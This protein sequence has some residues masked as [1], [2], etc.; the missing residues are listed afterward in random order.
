MFIAGLHKLTLIDYPGKVAAVVFTFGCN[1]SCSFCHNPELV[2]YDANNAN[3][4]ESVRIPEKDFF[5]FLKSRQGLLEGVCVTGGEPTLQGD[6]KEFITQ[7]KELGFLVKL[8]TNG[9]N[10]KLIEELIHDKLINYVAMDIKAPLERYNEIVRREVDLEEIKKSIK[11]TMEAGSSSAVSGNGLFSYEFRSTLV[12]G[13]H[14]IE[15]IKAMADLIAGAKKYFLQNFI[16]QGKI[17]NP[18]WINRRSFTEKE[19]KEFQEIAGKLVEKCEI[20]M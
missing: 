2:K 5:E 14:G 18:S 10:S 3:S 19:M 17:L 8:D 15:D 1:F 20:R 13:F 12:P 9:T 16:S 4:C 7:I 6:L 11:I